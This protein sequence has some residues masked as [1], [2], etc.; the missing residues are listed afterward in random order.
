V[1]ASI[2]VAAF[3]LTAALAG[4]AAA[5]PLPRLSVASFT[6]SADTRT[7][8]QEQPFHLVIDVRL[9][10]RVVDLEGVV[11]P[12]LGTLE[13]LGDEKHTLAAGSGTAYRETIAVVAHQGGEIR[14]PPAYLDAV[15]ARDGKPKRFLSNE[16]T[17][18]VA[19]PASV[20]TGPRGIARL[21]P[22]LG[23]L[24]GALVIVGLAF[25]AFGMRRP[26]AVVPASEPPPAEKPAVAL[27]RSDGPSE[28]AAIAR[29][30]LVRDPSR[31]GA[32]AA[33]SALWRAVGANDG[34]T[35]ADVVRRPAAH[36]PA[37]RA[38]LRALERAA[39]TDDLDRPAAIDDALRALDGY[40]A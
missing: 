25:A 32:L 22:I 19:G 23:F 7:P 17:L 2:V 21:L 28:A 11:L 24:A 16:L 35:L 13:I 9:N 3:A 31:E 6:F 8:A 39:F 29:E 30:R 15:D 10:G 18:H 34:E 27:A 5:D 26:A 20:L 36:D 14:I 33:R 1:R 4:A 40:R 37:L 38:V 12:Q